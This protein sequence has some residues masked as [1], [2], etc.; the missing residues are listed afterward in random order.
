MVYW[1][2]SKRPTISS[3]KVFNIVTAADSSYYQY[4]LLLIRQLRTFKF[5]MT[6]NVLDCGLEERQ[7]KHIKQYD[8]VVVPAPLHTIKDYPL[9]QRPFTE[10]PFLNLIFPEYDNIIWLD[11]DCFVQTSLFFQYADKI[12]DL[13][14]FGAVY[15]SHP[16]YMNSE[17]YTHSKN[18][19]SNKAVQFFGTDVGAYIFNRATI[20]SGVIIATSK[21][22][23]WKIWQDAL[24]VVLI[25]NEGY[26]FGVDQLSLNFACIKCKEEF[27]P[28]NARM[29]WM[30]HV[31]NPDIKLNEFRV[32]QTEELIF[33]AHFAERAKGY[34]PLVKD[35]IDARDKLHLEGEKKGE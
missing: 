34:L 6:I 30:V 19:M 9:K 29:N 27:V 21:S 15:E 20:N 5:H 31:S 23:I 3:S 28:M 25:K 35:I 12:L 1:Q 14:K 32:P 10:R 11:A 7:V 2:P 33:V 8:V 16:Q 17:F 22:P 18:W 4:A 24:Q 26:F 13:N